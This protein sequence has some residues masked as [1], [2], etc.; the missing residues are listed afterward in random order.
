MGAS[1]SLHVVAPAGVDD[2]RRPSGGN[3][4][5]RRLCQALTDRGW[6]VVLHQ[7]TGSWPTPTPAD[8][9]GL[10]ALL[11]GLP[12]GS[13]VLVD[14]LVGSAVPDE[15]ERQQRRLRQA[16]LVHLPL[17][18]AAE[19]R[20]LRSV[21]AVVATS[22]WTR[23]R[24]VSRAGLEPRCVSVAEPGVDPAPPADGTGH[25]G[26][27]LCV[28]PVSAAKGH[29]LL[30]TALAT[31][32]EAEWTLTCVGPLDRETAFVSWF[33]DELRRRELL[34]RVILT[35]P[36]SGDALAAVYAGCDLLVLPSRRE[37]YGMVV[38]E[39]LARAVPAVVSDFGGLPATL[40]RLGD[41]RLPGAVVHDVD[42]LARA[43]RCWLYDEEHRADLRDA[44]ARRRSTLT[45]WPVTAARV[46]A[47][48]GGAA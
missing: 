8:R 22:S 41:G 7:V 45:G 18:D 39:A 43:L 17:E 30:L 1:R 46:A 11:D 23:Q 2:P 25:G 4:Y 40:A 47:A 26:R 5:D 27:L 32:S 36:L 29:D 13:Q 44:A 10:D 42:D 31:L 38:T 12:D 33:V 24:L 28:G 21:H 14:G 16:V 34:E 6:S 15:L 9:R 3:V 35:G 37:S 19:R 20:A 48:F